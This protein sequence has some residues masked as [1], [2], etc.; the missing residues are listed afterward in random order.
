[1]SEAS[2]ARRLSNMQSI[3]IKQVQLH[4]SRVTAKPKGDH[5]TSEIY[6]IFTQALR[7]DQG[8]QM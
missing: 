7:T 5:W 8:G 6:P 2:M 3:A 1:M 4:F